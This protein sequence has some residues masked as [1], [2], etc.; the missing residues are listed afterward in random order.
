MSL[1]RPDAHEFAPYY[2]NYIDAAARWVG[3]LAG[4]TLPDLLT[5]QTVETRTLLSGIDDDFA[6]RA[7][8]PGKWTLLESLQHVA[9]AERVFSYRMLSIGRGDP[10]PLPGFDQDAWVPNSRANERTL[11]DILTELDVVRASTLALLHSLDDE[12]LLHLGTASGNPVSARALAWIIGGH[13]AHHHA[14]TR[15]RYLAGPATV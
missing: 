9:D 15:D 8:A 5:I 3:E 4:G 14:L 6:R 13:Y 12:S 11:S 7:Y 10:S 2:G 1:A